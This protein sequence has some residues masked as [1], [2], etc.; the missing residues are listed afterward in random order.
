MLKKIIPILVI[1]AVVASCKNNPKT[2]I[3]AKS[4]ADNIGLAG[5]YVTSDYQKRSEGYDWVAVKVSELSD[6]MLH[7]SIRSRADIKK[8]TCTFDANALKMDSTQNYIA[9][10]EGNTVLFIFE[11]DSMVVSADPGNLFSNP[12]YFCSGGASIAGVYKKIEEPLDSTQIDKVLFRKGLNYKEFAFFIELYGKKLT[13][14]PI[15]LS[16]DDHKVIH[17]IE[18]TIVN[19]EVGDLNIDGFPEVLI[20]I[21]SDGS[22]SYGSLIGYS[23]NK[24]K[25]MSMI[26]NLPPVAENPEA[27]SG[28][29]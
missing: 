15:G 16:I 2:D 14:Q 6:S 10:I 28:Y 13:I 19:A 1:F 18:G 8:P 23:V 24:G 22:G 17:E 21:Q 4:E 9:N 27:S 7:I 3:S 11:A 29:M 12:N 5:D 26:A 25:S 20:Y